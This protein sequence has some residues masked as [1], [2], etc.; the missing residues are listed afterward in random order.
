[1]TLTELR[2]ICDAATPGPWYLTHQSVSFRLDATESPSGYHYAEI[3]GWD[4]ERQPNAAFIAAARTYMPLLIAVA[5][6]AIRQRCQLDET[7]VIDELKSALA[8][9]EDAK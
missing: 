3:R 7:E 2:A 4:H 8:A 1:M 9:L 6:A 5:E